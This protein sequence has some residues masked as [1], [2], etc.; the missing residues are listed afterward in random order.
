MYTPAHFRPADRAKI[1][2]VIQSNSFATLTTQGTGGLTASHLPFL[3]DEG[4]GPHG[5][6]YAHMARA[7]GHWRDFA[8]AAT[9]ALVI[10]QGEHGY[11]SPTWYAS[12]ASMQHVPT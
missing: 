10:F 2:A 7:N 5:T 6:L 4:T 9:E 12:Y 1:T 3:Y 8:T 11:I